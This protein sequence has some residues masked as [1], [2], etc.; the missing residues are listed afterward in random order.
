MPIKRLLLVVT[1]LLLG[2]CS[3][4]S[5]TSSDE[6]ARSLAQASTATLEQSSSKVAVS[7]SLDSSEQGFGGYRAE[8]AFDYARSRGHMTV[9][10][11]QLPVAAGTDSGTVE[12]IF[13]Q[14]IVYMKLPGLQKSAQI[15]KPW[16]K[17][18]VEQLQ[19][20]SGA[21]G[22]FDAFGQADPS[23]YL[24]FVQ[25]AGKVS[26]VG[27]ATV[28]GVETTHYK[29]I[30][31]LDEAVKEAPPSM[32]ESLTQ[33]IDALG[34]KSVPVNAWIDSD[35]LLRRVGYNFEGS[36]QTGGLSSSITVDLYD[37]GTKVEVRLPPTDQVADLADILSKNSF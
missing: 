22:Q 30:A 6:A 7:V 10:L 12:V 36:E 13:D 37:F 9:D 28:R 8:G 33:A 34:S 3:E 1:V 20:Q 35:G 31:D 29:A 15:A 19:R 25:G 18:D 17:I 26:E 32:R 11:G 4:A 21:A 27:S 16:V 24:Q 23:Q 2:A 14:Q 5:S